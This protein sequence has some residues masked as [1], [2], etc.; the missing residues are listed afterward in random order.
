[1]QAAEG[2]PNDSRPLILA[3][4]ARLVEGRPAEALALY[5]RALAIGE[6]GKSISISDAPMN[7]QE[8][9]RQRARPCCA[10]CGLVRRSFQLSPNRCR[11]RLKPRSPRTLGGSAAVASQRRLRCPKATDRTEIL[12]Q[13]F[14]K[15]C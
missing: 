8:T 9:G 4:S 5:R 7:W 6:R 1:M 10:R 11:P 13:I 14:L 3:G 15:S 12:L 2:L